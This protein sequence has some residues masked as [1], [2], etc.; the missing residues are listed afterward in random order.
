MTDLANAS[1][2]RIFTAEAISPAW[3][4]KGD[5]IAFTDGAGFSH[6]FTVKP[7]GTGVTKLTTGPG[8]D[9]GGP[10]RF[11]PAWSPDGSRIAF[12]YSQPNYEIY[13]MAADGSDVRNLSNSPADDQQANSSRP[14]DAGR[15]QAAQGHVATE[16]AWDAPSPERWVA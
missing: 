4:P 8:Q 1:A 16:T 7:D 11:D 15:G 3:S 9:Q 5:R 2:T 14:P 12:G 10:D 6:I 13:S